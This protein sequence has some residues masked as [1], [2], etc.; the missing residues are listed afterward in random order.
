MSCV[1]LF[2]VQRYKEVSKKPNIIEFF[3]R[4]DVGKRTKHERVVAT[5]TPK[6]TRP[7]S[8]ESN[9][10]FTRVIV[11][12]M[13]CQQLHTFCIQDICFTH[14]TVGRFEFELVSAAHELNPAT[15][16]FLFQPAPIVS[17]FGIVGFIVDGTNHIG[18]GE[19]PFVV[20]VAPHRT[21][22]AVDILR[23]F[24]F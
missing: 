12:I 24:L 23:S 14:L 16:E 21:N 6:N 11:R 20:G 10:R 5:R 1:V 3:L 2:S 4:G 7:F 15:R 22:F 13:F 18:C 17:R 9:H 19:I 8:L